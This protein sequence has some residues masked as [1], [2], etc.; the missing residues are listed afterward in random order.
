MKEVPNPRGSDK[1][2]LERMEELTK[3]IV[4]VPKS[5]LPKRKPPK[6]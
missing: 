2:P 5:E 4:R 6:T 3:R 1:T